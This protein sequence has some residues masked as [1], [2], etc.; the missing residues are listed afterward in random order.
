MP[1]ADK[2]GWQ[3]RVRGLVQGVGFRPTVWRLANEA[4][5]SGEVLNDTEGVLIRLACS[6]AVLDRFINDMRQEAP[7]LSRIDAVEVEEGSCAPTAEG[8]TIVASR[9]GTARTGIVPDATTCSDCLC[10]IREPDN[11]RFGYGFTNCT[12]CGP[13]LSITRAIPYDRANTAMTGFQMCADCQGEYDDPTDRRFHAQPNACPNCGPQLSLVGST[14]EE[15]PGDPIRTAADML[16]DGK[17]LAIKGLGGF[18][19]ACNATNDGAVQTLRIRKRRQAKPFALMARNAEQTGKYV[20]LNAAATEALNSIAAPIVLAPAHPRSSLSAAVAPEQSRLGFML[21]NTPL[22]HLLLDQLD[23]PLVMTSGNLSSEPQVVDNDEAL[24][25]LAGIAD[26]WLMHNRDI[27]NRLDDSVV[28]IID[29]NAH[30]IRR[31]RGYAP[32]PLQLHEGFV[33]AP[34]VLAAG[35]DLKNTFCLLKDGQ[36]M[37]SQHMGD[38]ENPRCHADYRANLSLYED[39]Y[40]FSPNRVAIDAHPGYFSSRIGRDV[41]ARN[42]ITALEIQHHH[43]HIA[44]VLAEYG[45]GPDTPP[46]LGIVLDG[47]G[48]GTDDTIWGGEF[49]V[50]DYRKFRRVAHFIPVA[51]A[52]GDKANQQPWRNLLTHLMAVFG[53]DPVPEIERHFGS[54]A[55]LEQ[56][57]GKPTAMLAQTVE[58][59]VNAP[60][61]SSAGRLFDAVAAALDICFDQID[62]EGQAAMQLQ[63]LAETEPDECGQYPVQTGAAINWQGLWAGILSDLG[64]GTTPGVIAARFHNS[65]IS[66]ISDCA[67]EIAKAQSIDTVVLCGGVFQNALLLSGVTNRLNSEGFRVLTPQEI[68]A[69]DGGISLGQATIAAALALGSGEL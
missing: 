17:V 69:N 14:G 57:H 18:Q 29:K 42:D 11:R 44:A 47:L 4:G 45:L 10:D 8:F 2:S 23:V 50:A 7:P 67:V 68:P 46:V 34:N 27:A 37:V 51:L 22:H 25:R 60:L 58:Q 13:R 43:A 20:C 3:V 24:T 30:M 32:A 6:R 63:A 26:A 5:L 15:L 59:G 16:R 55:L 65:L 39:I 35:G 49:L 1:K 54:L 53:G 21:A 28:Q 64:A 61:A 38:M 48:W 12:N 9:S 31:A 41:A 19:L 56:V 62:F 66:V 40:D 52:G 33:G 36:A